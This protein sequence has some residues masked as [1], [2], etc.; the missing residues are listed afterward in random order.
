MLC[1]YRGIPPMVLFLRFLTVF[2]SS[3]RESRVHWDNT[4]CDVKLIWVDIKIKMAAEE[5]FVIAKC[6]E[7]LWLYKCYILTFI[8]LITFIVSISSSQ[9]FI[10]IYCSS[11]N[12]W[13]SKHLHCWH[14]HSAPAC[15][16]LCP[17]VNHPLVSWWL[18]A[19]ACDITA[20]S[21]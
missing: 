20:A 18:H 5:F 1:K 14:V 10:W 9:Y 7:Q 8:K 15:S 21:C 11:L 2:F 4:V 6:Y 17:P 16:S 3:S 13:K 19:S 12:P